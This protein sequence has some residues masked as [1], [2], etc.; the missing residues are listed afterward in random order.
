MD[1]KTNLE[2]LKCNIRLR[3]LTSRAV[4]GVCVTEFG[5]WKVNW[6]ISGARFQHECTYRL[7]IGL[8]GS[9]ICGEFCGSPTFFKHQHLLITN[10]NCVQWKS[11]KFP[12]CWCVK[13]VILLAWKNTFLG[14]WNTTLARPSHPRPSGQCFRPKYSQNYISR[15]WH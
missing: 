11:T 9:P 2:L 14:W 13:K 6:D 7:G 4:S 10:I 12:H 1:S 5:S 8:P 15:L 3:L